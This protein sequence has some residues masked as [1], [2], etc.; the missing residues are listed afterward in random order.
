MQVSLTPIS[1]ELDE[2][3]GG[4]IARFYVERD[5]EAR[6]IGARISRELIVNMPDAQPPDV[7]QV[8]IPEEEGETNSPKGKR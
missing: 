2:E 3:S 6:A 4:Y 1:I 8:V 5:D 7:Y